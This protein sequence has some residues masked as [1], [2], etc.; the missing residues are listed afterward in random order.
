[1]AVIPGI[2]GS[3]GL[4]PSQALVEA[5]LAELHHN[6]IMARIREKDYTVWKDS[7]VEIS[8]RLGWLKSPQVMTEALRRINN[9]VDE[10]RG[11]GYTHVLLLGMGGSSL[12]PE[13]FRK[14]FGVRDGY[15]DLAVLDSTD[16][17]AVLAHAGRI[18]P[19]KTLFVVSTKSGGTVETFSFLKYFYNY[20]EQTLGVSEAG[21]HFIAITDPGSTLA[22]LATEQRFRRTFLNDPDIGGRYSVLSYF[23]L[24]PAALI[25]MDIETLLCRAVATAERE[26]ACENPNI[27]NLNGASLG[28]VLGEMA[29]AGRDKVTFVISPGIASFGDWLEQLLAESTGKERKGILPVVGEPLGAPDV[30]GNDRL[31]VLLLLD[32]EEAVG[33]D[34]RLTALEKA[35]HPVVRIHLHDRYDLGSQCFLWEM[36]TAVAGHLL[37]VNPFD[38]PDVEA[39]KALTK[40]LIAEYAQ[41]GQFPVEAP[42]LSGDGIVVYGDVQAESPAAALAAFL[43][44]ADPGAYIALQ[45]YVQPTAGTDE[46]LSLLRTR[47]RDKFRLATTVG[48]GPRFLHSTGQ[49]H[50]GDSGRGLFIQFT[51]DD[52][53]DIPI[54]DELGKP[55]SSITFGVL[56]AAQALG[57]RQALINA[58]RRLVR[59]HLGRDVASSL[60]TL[61]K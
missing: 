31:F 25:G 6:R 58:G 12:A 40:K 46:A 61:G 38:Q 9:L 39:S 22:D 14:T 42:A 60:K 44:P 2:H 3:A 28:V 13:V 30:Y 54:P 7:P 23:G 18:T 37:G 32:G 36:A 50:K 51:A 19:A 53:Q 17:R 55:D 26:A 57:D 16:P 21:R 4:G 15:L 29:K 24:V 33:S 1:M 35:G 8:N 48:Y 41:K 20:V 27:N 52:P 59:F 10:V 47:L 56:K 34:G 11:D 45:A 49:L 43:R 5:V